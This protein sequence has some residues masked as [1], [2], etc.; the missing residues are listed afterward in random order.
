M[1]TGGLQA[2][3]GWSIPAVLV[4]A[5]LILAVSGLT[6]STAMPAKRMAT[7]TASARATSGAGP[8]VVE[9]VDKFTTDS[10]LN[11]SAWVTNGPA[12]TAMLTYQGASLLSPVT[13]SLGFSSAQ[14]MS[15]S[16]A[17]AD[18]TFDAVQT[19]QTFLPPF[20]AQATVMATASHGNTFAFALT[21]ANAGQGMY[22]VGDLNATNPY[23][24]IGALTSVGPGLP[25][26]GVRVLDA[27]PSLDTWYT[28][29]I[30]VNASGVA[31]VSV[32]QGSAVVGTVSYYIG[33]GAYYLFLGQFVDTP[34]A[35][36][37]NSADWS[38]VYVNQTPT[39]PPPPTIDGML[40]DPSS[41]VI[42][43]STVLY[44][45]VSGGTRPLTTV[46]SGLPPGCNSRSTLAL[47]CSPTSAGN[48]TVAVKVTDATGRSTN[49]EANLSV[50]PLPIVP[51]HV[52]GVVA[53]PTSI[54]LGGSTAFVVIVSGGAVP[55]SVSYS[56]LPPGCSSRSTTALDC[57]PA[58]S[59]GFTVLVTV[60]DSQG[61]SA[62]GETNVTVG[63][64]SPPAPLVTPGVA[65]ALGFGGV[66]LAVGLAG[67]LIGRRRAVDGP[68][69]PESG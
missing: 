33:L 3:K 1:K 51:P 7:P 40:A 46:Y 65:V 27:T 56:G 22:Q 9:F 57:T 48:Y 23:Y 63:P 4:A 47:G 19:L 20:D 45:F 53:D 35:T 55:L 68:K 41:I 60:T 31:A 6:F 17:T 34:P 49:S 14:G 12:A 13:P 66:A 42:G 64:S 16:G 18:Y 36:G 59:G 62:T 58:H 25:W 50:G 54:T 29:S 24:S 30:D 10:S 2:R 28:L 69:I 38:S 39:S 15:L 11:S 21:T 32:A 37:A 5:L 44:T 43:G 67:L 26:V 8:S 52:Y 61:R